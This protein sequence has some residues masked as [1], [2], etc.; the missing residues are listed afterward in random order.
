MNR[1]T[2]GTFV[3]M[4]TLQN[5]KLGTA[6]VTHLVLL[7]LRIKMSITSFVCGSLYHGSSRMYLNAGLQPEKIMT[8]AVLIV[9]FVY[10]FVSSVLL[11]PLKKNKPKQQRL[12]T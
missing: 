7:S 11:S 5:L 1:G 4:Q 6:M 10:I 9:L 3:P 2:Y 12:T 8:E